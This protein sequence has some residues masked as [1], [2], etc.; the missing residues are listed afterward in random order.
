M[1]T[2]D[3]RKLDKRDPE[4][5][6]AINYVD[7]DNKNRNVGQI[8]RFTKAKGKWDSESKI[9]KGLY[10]PESASL[11]IQGAILTDDRLLITMLDV[12]QLLSP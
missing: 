8:V 12:F 3:T 7:Y 6:L 11:L 4:T 9:V 2:V 10:H 1:V 5:I